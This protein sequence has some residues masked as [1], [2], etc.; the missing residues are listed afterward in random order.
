MKSL[1]EGHTSGMNG[2]KKILLRMKKC[3]AQKKKKS[4]DRGLRKI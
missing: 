2:R 1:C 3:L 4:K